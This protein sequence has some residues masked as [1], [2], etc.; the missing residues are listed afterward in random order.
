MNVHL[1]PLQKKMLWRLVFF[2]LVFSVARPSQAHSE[3]NQPAILL[4]V[5]DWGTQKELHNTIEPN[6]PAFATLALHIM[7]NP[8]VATGRRSLLI[9]VPT[10]QE[11]QQAETYAQKL[12]SEGRQHV[13]GLWVEMH[14]GDSPYPTSFPLKPYLIFSQPPL[15]PN[16]PPLGDNTILGQ[17]W[18]PPKLPISERQKVYATALDCAQKSGRCILSVTFPTQQAWDDFQKWMESN[19]G[20]V[21]WVTLAEYVKKQVKTTSQHG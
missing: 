1:F 5:A 10:T 20:K 16:P 9:Q 21:H 14:N 19:K 12:T 2:C 8:N 7:G 3:N 13:Q 6:I 18:V 11:F 4:I 17:F 15:H